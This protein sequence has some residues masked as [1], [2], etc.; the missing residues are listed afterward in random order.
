MIE[1]ETSNLQ[2][3]T[4]LLLTSQNLNYP[5]K[6]LIYVKQVCTS[7]SNQVKF[8]NPKS[9]IPSKRSIV[10]L[11]TTLNPRKLKWR[12]KVIPGILTILISTTTNH[13]HGYYVNIASF[14]TAEKIKIS[15]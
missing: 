6:N 13:F 9:S 11:P 4:K 3:L 7:L 5:K 12:E 14:E 1:N 15:L 8:K 2:P 10:R